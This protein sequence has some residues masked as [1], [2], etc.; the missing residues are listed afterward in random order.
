M[1]RELNLQVWFA[2]AKLRAGDEVQEKI[3]RA[4]SDHDRLLLVLTEHSMK[5]DWVRI[6]IRKARDIE[7]ESGLRKLI[8]I[9]LVDFAAIES[10]RCP[11]WNHFSG[12]GP[13]LADYVRKL[14]I[15]DFSNWENPESLQ[16]AFE[17]LIEVLIP[18]KGASSEAE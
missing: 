11:G 6:E 10:W 13:D 15:P 7:R 5:S 18:K 9:R 4:I 12:F 8:P 3:R 1:L 14:F 16:A 17:S 2:P